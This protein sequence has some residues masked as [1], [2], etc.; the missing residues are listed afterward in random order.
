MFRRFVLIVTSL[1]TLLVVGVW[2]ERLVRLNS[3]DRLEKKA[4]E[5]RHR[6]DELVTEW[7][8][9][10]TAERESAIPLGAVRSSEDI[11]A[12]IALA[13]KPCVAAYSRYVE[14]RDHLR[15]TGQ[16]RYSEPLQVDLSRRDRRWLFVHWSAHVAGVTIGSTDA[17]PSRAK[18]SPGKTR[19]VMLMVR[20]QGD[21]EL[22]TEDLP[23]PDRADEQALATWLDRREARKRAEAARALST[24][25]ADEGFY[26]NYTSEP[27]RELIV[28][29]PFWFLIL[30]VSAYPAYALLTGPIRR[31]IRRARGSCVK[32]AYN[33]TGN[34]S[35]VCPE[36]GTAIA[37]RKRAPNAALK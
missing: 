28:Q 12:D 3:V 26:F 35:G 16:K 34:T 8:R 22:T 33:L 32:C 21:L 2:I 36:C 25:L 37:S 10:Q 9:A 13:F 17:V 7:Q 5:C 24:L 14:A 11:D 15:R 29:L 27:S 6:Y 30:V 18:W 4:E 1:M 19:D 23:V 20:R 31:R